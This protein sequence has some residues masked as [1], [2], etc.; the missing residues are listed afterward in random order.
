MGKIG[1][2]HFSQSE[3]GPIVRESAVPLMGVVAVVNKAHQFGN[4][5]V[6]IGLLHQLPDL[7]LNKGEFGRVHLLN[8]VIFVDQLG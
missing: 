8:L 7:L 3:R 4:I 2:V 5:S 6:E 1:G